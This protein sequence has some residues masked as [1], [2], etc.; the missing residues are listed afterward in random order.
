M[1]QDTQEPQKKKSWWAEFSDENKSQDIVTMPGKLGVYFNYFMLSCFIIITIVPVILMLAV[2][3]GAQLLLAP[4][5]F[6]MALGYW[7]KVKQNKS[8]NTVEPA[9]KSETA[10]NE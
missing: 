7:K 9:S 4:F 5:G 6:F 2:G 8:N 10:S 3:P 1:E